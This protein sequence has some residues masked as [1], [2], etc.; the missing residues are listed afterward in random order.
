MRLGDDGWCEKTRETHGCLPLDDRE[1]SGSGV[2]ATERCPVIRQEPRPDDVA[3]PVN[4]ACHQ[5]YLQQGGKLVQ[6]FYACVWMH[7]WVGT[8]LIRR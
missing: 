1:L 8:A 7:L 3:T 2:F 5:W 6:V 4:G